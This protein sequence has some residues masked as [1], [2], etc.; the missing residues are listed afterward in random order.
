MTN[1]NIKEEGSLYLTGQCIPSLQAGEYELSAQ[2]RVSFSGK[3][4]YSAKETKRFSVQGQRFT[5]NQEQIMSV[6]PAPGERC[7]K[8]AVL[9]HVAVRPCTFP[10]ECAVERSS[11]GSKKQGL[12]TPFLALLLFHEEEMPVLV[13]GHVRDL[14]ENAGECGVFYSGGC[15][16]E[17]ADLP[18]TFMDVPGKLFE[19]IA[20]GA[21]E[22]TYL[23]HGRKTDP[24]LK[25]QAL[26]SVLAEEVQ[27][28]VFCNRI[29][30]CGT[31]EEPCRNHACL[32]S[33][34]GCEGIWE[35]CKNYPA[36]RLAVLHHWDF[37]VSE[38]SGGAKFLE[39]VHTKGMALPVPEQAGEEVKALLQ[40]GYVLFGHQ[41]RDGSKTAS[42]YRGP[43][44]PG[45]SSK[46][47]IN[48]DSSDAFYRYDPESGMFDVSYACAWEIGKLIALSDED[49][50]RNMMLTRNASIQ[51]MRQE[52]VKQMLSDAG[53]KT[54]VGEQIYRFYEDFYGTEVKKKHNGE[55]NDGIMV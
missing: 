23:V 52:A 5:A 37:F 21:D 6:Y 9:P 29:P 24:F 28:V 30:K 19:R 12:K 36:V 34:A 16:K 54:D 53:A 48:G 46:R 44:V 49:A 33:L 45:I 43:L 38:D 15:T 7:K 40:N 32:V 47:I 50:A 39:E 2:V 4:E 17:E 55:K 41:F 35:G 13:H 10:F 26:S 27:S 51:R 1:G 18:C 11:E 22:L 3:T 25:A 42:F 8:P 20:P 31:D 14:F